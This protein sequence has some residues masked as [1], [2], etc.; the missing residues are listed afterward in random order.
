MSFSDGRGHHELKEDVTR[1]EAH[2]RQWTNFVLL[3][4]RVF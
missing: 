2:T 4:V 3:F 1:E